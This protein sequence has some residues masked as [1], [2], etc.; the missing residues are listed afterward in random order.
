MCV[1]SDIGRCNGRRPTLRRNLPRVHDVRPNAPPAATAIAS[2]KFWHP[3][4]TITVRAKRWRR[5]A[6]GGGKSPSDQLLVTLRKTPWSVMSPKYWELR[7]RC[8]NVGG[9]TDSEIR[10][11]SSDCVARVKAPA[12]VPHNQSHEW[13]PLAPTTGESR[14]G[15][16]F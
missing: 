10:V 6:D 1:L 9:C 11:C 2:A 12:T 15:I 8:G 16:L 13:G 4:S 14:G 3:S 5:V 7:C